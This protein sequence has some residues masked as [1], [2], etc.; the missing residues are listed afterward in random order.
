M[1]WVKSLESLEGLFSIVVVTTIGIATLKS[2]RNQKR[3]NL[4]LIRAFLSQFR[5]NYVYQPRILIRFL[6]PCAWLGSIFHLQ[7]FRHF[8]LTLICGPS[9]VK[10]CYTFG[11]FHV[12][13]YFDLSD[14]DKIHS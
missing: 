13:V 10:N 1:F 11:Y 7:L 9:E 2:D 4:S 8:D 6:V 14:Y 3:Y 5:D 12:L